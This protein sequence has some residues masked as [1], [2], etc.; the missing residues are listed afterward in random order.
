MVVLSKVWHHGGVEF[1]RPEPY[2]GHIEDWL[3]YDA[4]PAV[5]SPAARA[6]RRGTASSMLMAAMIGV[7][8][9]LG[10]ERPSEETVQVCDASPGDDLLPLTFGS[11]DP[12]DN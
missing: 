7:A 10:Y 11:L 8:E 12:L 3:H 1:E 6:R 2:D 5:E 9:A 4:P